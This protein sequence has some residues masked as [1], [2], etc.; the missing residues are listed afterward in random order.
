VLLAAFAFT[1]AG[2]SLVTT[3]ATAHFSARAR[4]ICRRAN[5]QIEALAVPNDTPQSEAGVARRRVAYASRELRQLERLTPPRKLRG[6]FDTALGTVEGLVTL[7]RHEA[8]DYAK[9]RLTQA[10]ALVSSGFTL[11][12]L[13]DAA[14]RKLGLSDCAANPQPSAAA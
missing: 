9:G 3:T 11:T 2:C 7:G 14:M 1:L 8:S 13:A 4:A 12:P 5:L 6:A 10:E